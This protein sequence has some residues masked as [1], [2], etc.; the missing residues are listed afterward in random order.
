MQLMDTTRFIV[1]VI[2]IFLPWL[3]RLP[4]GAAWVEQ[5]TDVSLAG[6]LFFSA[7]NAIAWGSI[8][9]ISYLYRRPAPLLI[10]CLLGFG[11]LT[12]GHS[13]LDLASDAQ[14]AV[15][16]VFI[17]ILALPAIALGGGLGLALDRYLTRHHP[18]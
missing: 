14:A 5:Y 6:I 16:L 11:V 3:V 13:T 1:A 10:P 9:A 2:G 7:C 17:P 8:I 4:R 12:W 15:A 18:A